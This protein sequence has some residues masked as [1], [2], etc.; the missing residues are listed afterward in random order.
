MTRHTTDTIEITTRDTVINID[1]DKKTGTR[2]TNPQKLMQEEIAKLSAKERAIVIKN[3]ETIGMNMATQMGGEVKPKAGKHLGYPCD[4]VTVMGST[5][6]QMS[7]TPIM[8]KSESNIMGIKIKTVA[9]KIDKNASVSSN[10]FKIPN[11]VKVK[12]SKEMDDMNRQM[13]A[14]MVESMKDP[15][16]P[17]K[18]EEGMTSGKM[19]MEEARR[20]EAQERQHHTEREQ[21]GEVD[22]DDGGNQNGEPDEKELD[23]MMQKGMDTLKGLFK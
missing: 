4:L 23:E 12:H 8:L 2:M 9:K 22:P 6:C 21:V 14:S 13:I 11:G 5:S 19:Q 1:M 10:I 16:A 7:G 20:Q 18:F 15:D 3:L 17:K